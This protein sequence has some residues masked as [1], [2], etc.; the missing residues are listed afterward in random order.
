MV[1]FG[2][3]QDVTKEHL[4]ETFAEYGANDETMRYEDQESTGHEKG[5]RCF[6][7]V[8]SDDLGDQLIAKFGEEGVEVN[9]H[10]LMV[11]Y[12]RNPNFPKWRRS[13][14]CANLNWNCEE[15]H[16]D[17]FFQDCGEILSIRIVRD[18]EGRSR[19]FGF[20]EFLHQRSAQR[21]QYKDQSDF[22]G[23]MITVS[24]QQ[25]PQPR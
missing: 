4:L 19:G 6:F 24:L 1:I 2:I 21:A 22:L 13:I 14:Y 16:L 12:G 17:E 25:K 8:G 15:W 23:R 10:K 5:G 7:N 3:P 11:N 18:Q 20:V 9:G